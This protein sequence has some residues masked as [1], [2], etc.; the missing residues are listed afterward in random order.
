MFSDFTSAATVPVRPLCT[1]CG[2]RW[3]N[4]SNDS[5]LEVRRR[6]SDECVWYGDGLGTIHLDLGCVACVNDS[7]YVRGCLFLGKK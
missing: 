7:Y 4:G 6:R 2:N 5:G 3:K 1:G